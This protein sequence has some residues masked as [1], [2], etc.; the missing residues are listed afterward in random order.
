MKKLI[1]IGPPGA[2]K[3]TAARVIAEK[4]NIPHISTGD[5]F[6]EVASRDDELGR[7]IKAELEQGHLIDDQITNGIVKERLIQ[8]D[9]INGYILDGYPRSLIQAIEFD[10]SNSESDT[11]EIVILFNLNEEEAVKRILG[12]LTCPKCKASYNEN[13]EELRPKQP[14]ICDNCQTNLIRRGDDEEK[15]IRVRFE[16]YMEVT[17]PLIEYYNKKGSLFTVASNISALNTLEQIDKIID[18][19]YENNS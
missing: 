14:G 3:G 15:A 5:I 7:F 13:A 8:P 10:A 9:C 4:Y 18:N 19:Y 6:R 12:R 11:N 2:G 16:K 1:L 17:R